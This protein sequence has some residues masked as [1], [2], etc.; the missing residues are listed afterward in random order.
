MIFRFSY[1]ELRADICAFLFLSSVTA[2]LQPAYRVPYVINS[3]IFVLPFIFYEKMTV[4]R[5]IVV[6]LNRTFLC[7][8]E[9]F[10]C[11]KKKIK[12]AFSFNYI[13]LSR[14]YSTSDFIL[15]IFLTFVVTLSDH[16]FVKSW[17]K[18]ISFDLKLK[19][20]AICLSS[21]TESLE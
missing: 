3:K 18:D 5:S 12:T 20:Y 13:F 8:R 6:Y 7:I 21:E 11:W 19:F 10:R 15:N 2:R 9:R 4:L 16:K 14:I 17:N 1:L